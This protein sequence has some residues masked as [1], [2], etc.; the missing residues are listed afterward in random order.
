MKLLNMLFLTVIIVFNF[1]CSNNKEVKS[2]RILVSN[3]VGY[4]PLLYAYEKGSLDKFN[5]DIIT[6]TSLQA[7]LRILEKNRLDGLFS[8]LYL[9]ELFLIKS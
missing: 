5:I 3:W 1:G 4:T 8:I 9:V 6:T 7:S 2:K